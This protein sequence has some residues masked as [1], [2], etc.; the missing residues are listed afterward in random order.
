MTDILDTID[1]AT[2][3]L[4]AC[5]CGQPLPPDGPSGWWATEACQR[6][7]QSS[8]GPVIRADWGVGVLAR[9]WM[10]ERP[11]RTLTVR[12][13]SVDI[14]SLRAAMAE[15]VVVLRRFVPQF[16][17]SIPPWFRQLAAYLPSPPPAPP[18]DVMQ[19]AIEAKRNRN[20]GPR[21]QPRAPRRI[22][23]TRGR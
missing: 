7:W 19:R 22:D 5:G 9:A 3:A 8:Q 13:A 16:A 15:S 2:G 1:A 4:C 21:V 23:P 20:T 6:A 17:D 11:S 14:E 12:V 18:A 10:R